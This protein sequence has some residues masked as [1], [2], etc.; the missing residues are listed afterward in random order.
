MNPRNGTALSIGLALMTAAP[1]LH[2]AEKAGLQASAQA[3]P[4]LALKPEQEKL[5]TAHAHFLT[6]R[7]LENEGRMREA[8]GHYLAFLQHDPGEPELVAHIAELALD[9]QGM[10]AAVKLLEESIKANG[11]RPE[12]YANFTQFALTHAD[13][14]DGLLTRAAA[15]ADEAVKRFPFDSQGY[16]VAVRLHLADALRAKMA[17]G[18]DADTHVAAAEKVLDQAGKQNV[19]DPGYWL[20]LG[21]IALE[22]WPLADGENRATHL[23]KV[24]PFFEKAT[25]RAQAMK[26]EEAELRAA[27]YY[28]FS[29]QIDKAVGICEA[30]VK[31]TGSLDSRKRL[32]RL[33][34]AMERGDDSFKALQD[35]VKAYPRDVEHRKFIAEK[36]IQ[37]GQNA[38]RA[39][40]PEEAAAENFKAV[41]HLEAALQAGGGDLN[42]YLKISE[43]LRFSQKSE[44][45]DRFTARAQQLYPGEPRMGFY[46]AAA[47]SQLKEYV[48][49]AMAFEESAKLAETRAPEILDDQFHFAWG[50]ALE[51]SGQFD[52][53][54]K[55]FQKSIDLTPPE[56]PPRAANTMN[57]LGYMWLDRGQHLDRAETL[58]R[59]ANEM[60]PDNGAFVDSLGWLLF[61]QGK[62]PEALPEL[63]RAEKLLRQDQPEPEPGDAEIYDHIAQT[64]DKLG[65][66]DKALEYWRQALDVKPE[67][68]A[69]RERA[70]RELGIAKPKPAKPVSP[71]EEKGAPGKKGP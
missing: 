36:Y 68:D 2:A 57:Y 33:Y 53:A 64:Y 49:A 30:V 11:H 12:P 62:F 29:N 4:D 43:L 55:E 41:E 7:M 40:K 58:I 59:K 20:G 24:N 5:A 67:V 31:R 13:E 28:L 8:L 9:Y 52:D 32:V 15:L 19:P 26:D 16:T 45:F 14:G 38:A 25:Q 50:V 54:A 48:G 44:E 42:D 65:Q 37:R 70:E 51:R 27:D 60:D 17:G 18:K 3:A 23:A 46:R 39:M 47:L 10:D 66:R 22:V 56:A 6:A 35:L 71:E 1:L 63:L 69:I 34:D 61:K 21:R